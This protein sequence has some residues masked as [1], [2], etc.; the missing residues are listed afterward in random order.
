M[1]KPIK[2]NLPDHYRIR[3]ELEVCY[4]CENYEFEQFLDAFCLLYYDERKSEFGPEPFR[5][6]EIIQDTGIC[7]SYK[8]KTK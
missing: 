4:T 2:G 6:Y 8:R 1:R 5:I 7:D 3:E